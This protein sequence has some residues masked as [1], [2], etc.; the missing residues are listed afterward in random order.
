M[1]AVLSVVLL[2]DKLKGVGIS[3][4]LNQKEWQPK[5]SYKIIG[6]RHL[7]VSLLSNIGWFSS[8]VPPENL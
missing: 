2:G 8:F 3:A 4:Y 1:V 5:E 7:V 6:Y